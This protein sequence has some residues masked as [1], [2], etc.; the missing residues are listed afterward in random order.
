MHIELVVF[1]F[2]GTTV[3]E[4]DA[5]LGREIHG[6]SQAFWQLRQNAIRIAS[7]T[8]LSMAAADALHERLGWRARGLIDVYVTGDDVERTAPFPDAIYAAMDRAGVRES[9][10]VTLVSGVASELEQGKAAGCGLVVGVFRDGAS[11]D[12][13]RD[14]PHNVLL[15]TCGLVPELLRRLDVR[16]IAPISLGRSASS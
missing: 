16:R 10:R 8:P 4:S 11:F 2:V 7:V 14:A 9:G 6:S 15:P 13:L 5:D 1:G 12:R 3:A